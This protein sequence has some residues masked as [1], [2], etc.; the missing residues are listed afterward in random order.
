[1]AEFLSAYERVLGHEGGYV[2]DP[3]DR[4]GETYMGIS[5]KFNPQWEGWPIVD[6]HKPLERGE[7]IKDIILSGLVKQFY[8]RTQWDVINGDRINSQR[9]AEFL[10]DWFVNSGTAGIISAQKAIAVKADGKVGNMTLTALNSQGEAVLMT[11]LINA[12]IAFVNDIVRR[13]PSQKRFLK[14]WLNR[15]NSFK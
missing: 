9:A 7:V 11:K 5:R 3:T 2:N 6:S 14:G 4:G 10:F 1:M 15:I 8:K 12:R 13:N